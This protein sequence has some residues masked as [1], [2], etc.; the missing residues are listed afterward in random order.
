MSKYILRN[1]LAV[2]PDE[3]YVCPCCGE[4]AID[5][6]RFNPFYCDPKNEY[7]LTMAILGAMIRDTDKPLV[8][9]FQCLKC[10]CIWQWDAVRVNL[11]NKS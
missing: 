8:P 10:E 9:T 7:A 1:G 6:K 4:R 3:A 11:E 5:F 2:P